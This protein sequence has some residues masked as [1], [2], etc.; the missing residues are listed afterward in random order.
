MKPEKIFETKSIEEKEQSQEKEYKRLDDKEAERII[1]EKIDIKTLV[2]KLE[3]EFQKPLA[4]VEALARLVLELKDELPNYDTILSDE[5]SGRIPSLLL[6]NILEKVREREGKK[7]PNTYFISAGRHADPRIE[8]YVDKF[9]KKKKNKFGKT[10][11]VTEFID[12]GNS[13][14]K[15]TNILTEQDVDFNIA[16]VSISEKLREAT[17]KTN[18]SKESIKKLRVGKEESYIG[19]EFYAK[20]FIGVEKTASSN[21]AYPVANI[22]RNQ[23]KVNKV[24]K[25]METVADELYKLTE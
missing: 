9:I 12:T 25:D 10:L 13:I 7:E 20:E 21:N 18:L 5:V 16:S 14:E 19:L 3:I 1:D 22:F 2:D 8:S 24:R 11:L 15:I 4:V 6:G 17:K 23:E